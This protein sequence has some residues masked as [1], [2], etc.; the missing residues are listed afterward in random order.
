MLAIR[1][2]LAVVAVGMLL[3]ACG[4][5]DVDPR[6]DG[7][8]VTRE[9]TAAAGG[10]SAV[11]GGAGEMRRSAP[12]D[13]EG[14]V[15]AAPAQPAIVTWVLCA[16]EWQTCVLPSSGANTVRYGRDTTTAGSSVTLT[17]NGVGSVECSNPVFG[18]PTPGFVKRCW[19]GV[20]DGVAVAPTIVAA[21]IAQSVQAGAPA[22]FNVAAQGTAPLAYQW[23][24]NGV[25]IA[26][27]TTAQLQ[28][29]TTAADVGIASQISVRVSNSAGTVTSASVTLTVTAAPT[30]TT[31]VLCADEWQTC[32][33]P[34]S[35]ANTVRY[36]RDTTTAGSSVTR[37]FTGVGSVDCTNTVFGDPTP[38]FVKRCWYA[39]DSGVPVAPTIATAPT[40]QSVQ[41]GA[42]ATFNVVAQGTA[43]L[44][45]QWL[46]NGVAIAGATTAQLNLPTAA[47]EAGTTLQISVRVSNSAGTVTSA[48]V[49][50]TVTVVPTGVTWVLC[51]QESQTCVL[52]SSG[53]NTVRYGRDTTTAGSSV[54]LTFNGVGSVACTNTV[55]GDPTPGFVKRCWYALDS[56]VP[57]APTIATAPAAQTVQAGTTATFNVV[58]QGTAPLAYQWLRNGVAIAGATTAQLQLVT[59]AADVGTAQISVRV[60]NGA[61]SVTSA[62]ATLTVTAQV[63]A[64]SITT[65]PTPVSVQAGAT[66]TFSVVAQGNAPLAYQ[67]LRNGVAIAGAT[68]AQLQLVT[69]AAD[70]GTAQISV[71]VTNG[72]GSVTSASVV[73]TVTAAT[74]SQAVRLLPPTGAAASLATVSSDGLTVSFTGTAPVGVKSNVALVSGGGFRYFE[75]TRVGM[76]SVSLG[77]SASAPQSPALSGGAWIA[78]RDGIIVDEWLIRATDAS[79]QPIVSAAGGGA[80]F[81]FAV[82]FRQKY[83]VAYVIASVGEHPSSCAGVPPADPCVVRRV[84]LTETTGSLFIY[85]F[86]KGD[87]IAGTSV[88]INAG[89]DLLGRP[90]AYAM[91]DVHRALRTARL[92]GST[93]LNMTWPALSGNTTS[94]TLTTSS[95]PRVV[96]R[97]GDTS[98]VRSSFAVGV[99]DAA[100]ASVVRWVD[101]T[102]G[103][104]LLGTGTTLNL[105]A[106]TVALMTAGDHRVVA[107]VTDTATGRYGERVFRVT[108]L[109]STANGDDDGD[110]LTYTQ[111]KTLGTDPANPDTDGDGLSDGAEAG[112]G[113]LPG[114]ADSDGDGVLDG[115]EFPNTA[116]QPR[117]GGFVAEAGTGTGVILTDGGQRAA[118][119]DDVNPDCARNLA[120]FTDPVY[121]IE[122][123]RK[124]GVRTNA[125]VR[126]GEFRYF[127]SQR[128]FGRENMGHGVTTRAAQIDPFCCAADGVLHPLTPP[129][130]QY[131]SVIAQPLINL[132]NQ[133]V[134][135]L[136]TAD[137]DRTV[138]YGFVVDYRSAVNPDIYMVLV[139]AAGQVVVSEKFSLTGFNGVDVVPY[140]Y[141]HPLSDIDPHQEINL[142]LRKFAYAPS[143]IAAGLAAQGVSTLGFTPG[144]GL[145][146]WAP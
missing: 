31:W 123:C 98:P 45:Y 28:L 145:H 23:L 5:G 121:E 2:W 3:A 55:F 134:S 7:T 120:P 88:A 83:P 63:V 52:P 22:T 64:P 70:V 122:I 40:A 71:R 75:A 66:A 130:F 4:G 113:L 132:V 41:A 94:P 137:P 18:D 34:S 136:R 25:A 8:S 69:T 107:G 141:A 106:A 91:D 135:M 32:V 84:Q 54:T 140:G 65:P 110:G 117:V 43:P 142:G 21:P 62:A 67:W 114:V 102:A 126:A 104:T 59:T 127:E 49:T 58:A 82:D 111:E 112:L 99:V 97:Q 76:G 19:Y 48:T 44:A 57:V 47:G 81:G 108:V 85:A 118:F 101:E 139:D 125:A 86:G 36:G 146:R 105:S 93:G 100:A 37:A 20:D 74:G 128:L 10:T 79:A 51:A 124:R 9:S 30:G 12:S 61:G 87:N 39:V 90:F 15:L 60:T 56:G 1:K 144:V 78:S 33:L 133:P 96:V 115:F 53:A 13:L 95:Y 38:G 14:P 46:R 72:A 16:E 17:F 103:S 50:L 26:G 119:S 131:N 77:V 92:E 27:A 29:A 80:T 73:L 11:A 109:G 116:G 138:T 129:S 68:T 42:P 35:G 143:A 6:P 89:G 24:R